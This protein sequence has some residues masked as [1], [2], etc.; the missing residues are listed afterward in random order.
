MKTLI[1]DTREK[2]PWFIPSSNEPWVDGIVSK[3]LDYG[4]Y[5]IEGMENLCSIDRKR[6]PAE[7][8]ANLFS[9]RFERE[10]QRMENCKRPVILCEF[11]L[12]VLERFPRDSGIPKKKWR[13]LRVG[14]KNLFGKLSSLK[15]DYPYVIWLFA[16]STY[17]AKDIARSILKEVMSG[18]V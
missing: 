12:S 3:K 14:P 8:S 9:K 2:L 7:L 6:N 5:A 17:V 11:R 4:D 16:G 15:E 18:T 10:L 13:F 1:V